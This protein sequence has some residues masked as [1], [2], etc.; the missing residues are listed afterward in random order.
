MMATPPLTLTQ[1]AQSDLDRY[2][3]RVRAALRAHPSIDVEEVERDIRSHIEA[4]LSESP[5]PVSEARLRAVLDRLGSPSQWVPTDELPVWRKMLVRL[6]SGPEDWR[7][8]YLTFALFV[9]GPLAGSIG[10]LFFFAS[11]PMARASLALLEE[12]REPVGARRWLVYPPLIV[13]YVP[14]IIVSFVALPGLVATVAD[15]SLRPDARAWFPEPLWLSLPSVVA[16]AAGIW[17]AILGVLLARFPR[18]VQLSLWP[19]ADW[20]ERRHGIRIAVVGGALTMAAAGLFAMAW[21][22]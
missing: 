3:R 20:F 11:I 10:P 22:S 2:L 16:F 6:R 1:V 8:A 12:E 14:V 17:W 19:F 4:A 13:I 7:L 15:P 18:A 21:A 5:A 9:T